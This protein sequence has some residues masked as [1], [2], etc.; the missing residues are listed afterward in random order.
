LGETGS[1]VADDLAAAEEVEV[2]VLYQGSGATYKGVVLVIE[3]QR[4]GS[5]VVCDV[6]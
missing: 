3:G 4:K 1:G 5:G 2:V 6:G